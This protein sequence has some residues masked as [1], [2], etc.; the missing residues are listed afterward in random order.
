MICHDMR[1]HPV[2]ER[3]LLTVADLKAKIMDLPDETVVLVDMRCDRNVDDVDDDPIDL[4]TVSVN[5]TWAPE[6]HLSE[7]CCCDGRL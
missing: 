5:M 1:I 3:P 6:L 4:T 7:N 2:K